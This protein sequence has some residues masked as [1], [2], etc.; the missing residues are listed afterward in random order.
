MNDKF[1]PIHLTEI[2]DNYKR[3]L[4]NDFSVILGSPGSGK[5]SL[6]KYLEKKF[7]G[8]FFSVRDFFQEDGKITNISGKLLI[9]DGF[10]EFRIYERPKTDAIK[11]FARKIK[12]IKEK[13]NL[14]IILTCR[15]LDWY[16][17][18]D[19]QALMDILN[20]NIKIYTIK[21]ISKEIL[22]KFIEK[23]NI[24]EE[25]ESK[26]W[27][28]FE[29]GLIKTPQLFMIAKDLLEEEINNKI[30]LFEKFILKS[31]KETN[32]YHE[33]INEKIFASN[34]EKLEYLGYI[35]YIFMFS[36]I[37]MFDNEIIS[38][39]SSDK[40]DGRIISELLKSKIFQNKTFIHRTLAEFLC[41]KYFATLIK[42]KKIHKNLILNRF[43]YE[44][45]IYTELRSTY[46]WLCSISEDPD[47]IRIDPYYQ[48]IY[49]ENNHFSITFKQSILKSIRKYSGKNPYFLDTKSYYLKDGLKGF[50]EKDKEFDE[51]L[52]KEFEEAIKL[53]NHYLYI[54]EM[55]F[56]S[57]EDS[58][59][60][61]IKKFLLKKIFDNNVPENF[62]S[63]I[64]ETT[65]FSI[66]QKKEILSA[67]RENKISDRDNELKIVLLESLHETLN[68]NEIVNVFKSFNK[69]NLIHICKFLD[70][71]DFEK[72]KKLVLKIEEE[73]FQNDKYK[74]ETILAKWGC[75]R[76]FLKNFYSELFLL[77][78]AEDI[79]D[80]LKKV[81][82]L[83]KPH[84]PTPINRESFK[85]I[86]KKKLENLAN[87]LFELYLEDMD[88]NDKITPKIYEFS[89][90]FPLAF[91][92]NISNLLIKK[93]KKI[94]NKD[95]QR[96]LF[97]TAMKQWLDE[98]NFKKTFKKLSEEFG[99]EKEFK[100]F[101]NSTKN[102]E[103]IMLK[104]ELELKRKNVAKNNKI[105][106]N[107][108]KEGF[109]KNFDALFFISNL[110][111][112]ERND[113]IDN[114]LSRDIFEKYKNYLPDFLFSKNFLEY[115]SIKSLA[116]NL[117]NIRK[118]DRVF[119]SSLCLNKISDKL[120][121]LNEE[122]LKY[123]YLL[124][125]EMEGLNINFPTVLFSEFLEEKKEEIAKKAIYE[126]IIYKF[127]LDSEVLIKK[128][129]ESPLVE[130]KDLFYEI[131][132]ENDIVDPFLRTYKF[133]L[134]SQ[135]INALKEIN[136]TKSLKVFE[137]FFNREQLDKDDL[138]ILFTNIYSRREGSA[139]SAFNSL[140]EDEKI[141]LIKN[142]MLVFTDET[143]MPIK[144]GIQSN[145]DRTIFFVRNYLLNF[146]NLKEIE[147]LLK[148]KKLSNYWEKLLKSRHIKLKSNSKYKNFI[149]NE[150]KNFIENK[151]LLDE[152]DFFEFVSIEI[153]NLIDR[154][155]SNET[156]EKN[157]FWD[158]DKHKSEN[159]CRDAFCNLLTRPDFLTLTREPLIGNRKADI[160]VFH[161]TKNWKI[162]IECKL[163]KS[164][165]LFTAIKTQLI[166]K[167][168]KNKSTNYGIYLIFYFGDRKKSIEEI[169][170]KVNNNI[171]AKWKNRIK[172]KILNLSN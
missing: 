71:M 141:H 28:L 72:K 153:D 55:I 91:P 96:D 124:S 60:N 7:S 139:N 62:K 166:E 146:A 14:K 43:L 129:M 102:E 17:D 94:K 98:K 22:K 8:K 6:A 95:I 69:T 59:S 118:I 161:K 82:K 30:D 81:R 31:T 33:E 57:N 109:F 77:K 32:T 172:V 15:E 162:R 86:E 5:T 156:N 80:F 112:F 134:S 42:N 122:M 148:E 150:L 67:I 168:L 105:F 78:K 131:R 52:K 9:L 165:K 92:T 115:T 160:E 24:P 41:G 26:L 53:K 149:I 45:T 125:I 135:E 133:N 152:K 27:N 117:D 64:L 34:D 58:L 50:Y 40:Y 4:K 144:D 103:E 158:K 167:Y 140:S 119:Y 114:Y 171:P 23:E 36:D 170:S 29:K 35:A 47:L 66:K 123:L 136:Y 93:I 70:K 154:I 157:S 68:V 76:N 12:K 128:I 89:N 99:F 138:V 90:W 49:G 56:S 142:F 87:K 106:E 21:P 63:R 16:G 147:K 151:G 75:L 116:K 121:S 18:K 111:L 65:I 84:F 46:A 39:I 88:L 143:K 137:K 3:L 113:K 101:L 97:I 61:S 73:I 159:K 155:E 164:N 54:F 79:Y 37:E 108:S 145:L 1:I 13:K 25:K 19:T 126:L 51:F 20:V 74:Y 110:I 48:L 85:N 83:Y 163:D 100:N 10:D 107:L 2:E 11:T 127:E 130:L 132:Y 44:E 120:F 104:K 169:L 38:E